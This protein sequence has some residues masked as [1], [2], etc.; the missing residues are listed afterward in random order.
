VEFLVKIVEESLADAIGKQHFS[1][2]QAEHEIKEILEENGLEVISVAA[3][4]QD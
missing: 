2:A 4:E 3:T 1:N